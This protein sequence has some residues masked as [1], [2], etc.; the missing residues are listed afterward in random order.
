MPLAASQETR[1]W[2]QERGLG[3]YLKVIDAPAHPDA[4][5]VARCREEN[6][7]QAQTVYSVCE[8]ALT[9]GHALC[10]IVDR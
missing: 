6:R 1:S 2:L 7:P 4:Q 8:P 10:C 3:G 9:R 5:A